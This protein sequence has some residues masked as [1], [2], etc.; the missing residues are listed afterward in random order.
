M[1]AGSWSVQRKS[2]V[3][4]PVFVV[5]AKSVP[6]VTPVPMTPAVEAGPVGGVRGRVRMPLKLFGSPDQTID[7]KMTWLPSPTSSLAIEAA[8]LPA[9]D[10][11]GSSW[12]WV[13]EPATDKLGGPG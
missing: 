3:P 2:T 7:A 10:V 9:E 4:A 8:G 5:C 12:S 1:P 13:G 6:T 11:L